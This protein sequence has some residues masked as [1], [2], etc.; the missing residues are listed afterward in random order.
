MRAAHSFVLHVSSRNSG[1]LR[2][3]STV[4]LYGAVKVTLENYGKVY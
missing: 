3:H 4:L 2:A 1:C